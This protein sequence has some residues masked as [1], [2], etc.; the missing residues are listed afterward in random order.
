MKDY[1]EI[2]Y[3]ILWSELK[4]PQKLDRLFSGNPQRRK[5]KSVEDLRLT[6]AGTTNF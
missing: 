5:H 1:Q 4:S 3:S 2:N 6:Y